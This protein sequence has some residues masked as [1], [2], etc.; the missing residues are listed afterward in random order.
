M[1]G[2]GPGDLEE[3]LCPKCGTEFDEFGFC[4]TRCAKYEDRF[5]AVGRL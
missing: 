2:Y 5:K 3:M 1:C 4:S